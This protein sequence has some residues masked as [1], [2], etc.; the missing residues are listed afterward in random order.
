MDIHKLSGD[1]LHDFYEMRR[2]QNASPGE[3]RTIAQA[4]VDACI[5]EGEMCFTDVGFPGETFGGGY[6]DAEMRKMDNRIRFLKGKINKKEGDVGAMQN[7]LDELSG[8]LKERQAAVQSE[9]HEK[10]MGKLGSI[11]ELIQNPLNGMLKHD[12]GRKR[13]WVE[14][15]ALVQS[16]RKQEDLLLA[17]LKKDEEA[18]A[19]A[20]VEESKV[21]Q[22]LVLAEIK[23][24]VEA[25]KEETKIAKA[26]LAKAKEDA[27][28]AEVARD[29]A[30]ANARL[31]EAEAKK[32]EAEAKKAEAEANKAEKKEKKEKKKEKK[33]KKEKK[34]KSREGSDTD[35]DDLS[36][37]AAPSQPQA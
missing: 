1:E 34:E 10:V 21:K 5:E 31:M 11:E 27:T 37:Q 4:G 32:A 12:N 23:G 24:S 2:D 22:K 35:I 33:D 18:A 8:N 3:L 26:A 36:K 6:A 29:T 7:E 9:R 30:E 25:K 16:R 13:K 14:V 20:A 28:A 19:K 17:Q 15:D